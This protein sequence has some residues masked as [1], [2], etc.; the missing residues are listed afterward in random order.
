[1]FRLSWIP[2]VSFFA[3]LLL[4]SMLVDHGT[5]DGRLRGPGLT[6]DESFNIQQG[7]FLVDA[8]VQHGPLVF[9]PSGA[10]KVFGSPDYLPDHPPLGRAV[11][12]VSHYLTSWCIPG[13]ESTSYNVPAARLGSCFAFAMT[14]L[15]LSEFCQR[16]YGWA[17]A[18][19]VAILMISTPC[20]IGHARLAALESVTNLAWVAALL[21][22]LAWWTDSRPPSALR[23]CLSG[24]LWGLLLLTKVQGVLLPP[25]VILW[26]VWQYRW[27]GLRPLIWWTLC[28]SVVFLLAWP[29]LWL[30]PIHNLQ[31]YLGRT[32]DRPTLYCWYF[33]ERFADKQVPWHYPFVITLFTLPFGVLLCLLA[34][35]RRKQPDAVD[36]LLLLSIAAPL[37]VFALP[38]TPADAAVPEVVVRLV[39]LIEF[40]LPGTPVYD[41]NRLFLIVMPAIMVLAARAFCGFDDRKQGTNEPSHPPLPRTMVRWQAAVLG[42]LAI[43]PFGSPL[44]SSYAISQYGPLAGGSNGAARMEMEASYWSDGLNGSFW[45]QVPEN[46]TVFVAPVS[47]Q[48]QLQDIMSL[49]PIVKQRNI[50]LVPYEYDPDK[51]KGLLLLIHRLADLRPELRV[52]PPGATVIAE[53]RLDNVVLARLIDTSHRPN[54]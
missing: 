37:I 1:M 19:C 52:V 7:V 15:L 14:V 29:W 40:A 30:D 24:V 46:S 2:I 43:Q 53:A 50:R 35:V 31:Q 16:R 34:R 42:L 6:I 38:G 26:A 41:G 5:V 22:L 45:E 9:S 54:P 36:Q 28:G 13:S 17:S 47:H 48:F 23:A 8:L 4:S 11:L 33:G 21:P 27:Q 3:A 32:A 12:G 10:R 25:I 20:L 18:M 49:V 39:P 51:Q 44:F